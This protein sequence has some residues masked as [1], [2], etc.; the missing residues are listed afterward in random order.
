MEQSAKKVRVV[1]YVRPTGEELFSC[2]IVGGG[3]KKKFFVRQYDTREEALAAGEE[4]L[5]TGCKP[6]RKPRRITVAFRKAHVKKPRITPR[7]ATRFDVQ[8]RTGSGNEVRNESVGT[9]DSLAEAQ[10]AALEFEA[11]GKVQTF[12]R[13]WTKHRSTS[14]QRTPLNSNKKNNN[15][16][17]EPK[18]KKDGSEDAYRHEIRN[19]REP[20]PWAKRYSKYKDEYP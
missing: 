18:K 12:I 15:T 1:K 11:T 6:A 17:V 3:L 14:N 13:D 7:G 8:G 2:W 10:A 19:H 9:F 16:R 20:N 4:Y 5:V